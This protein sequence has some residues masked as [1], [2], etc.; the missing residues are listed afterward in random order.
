MIEITECLQIPLIFHDF[1]FFF[2]LPNS[3][4]TK[5]Q[6]LFQASGTLMRGGG[7]G[8]VVTTPSWT[9]MRQ[10]IGMVFTLKKERRFYIVLTKFLKMHSEF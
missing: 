6:W 8:V 5:F 10:L 4:E 2:F 1:S 3:Y 7:G 9:W